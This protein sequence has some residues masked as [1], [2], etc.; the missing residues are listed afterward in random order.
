MSVHFAAARCPARSP[1]ARAFERKPVRQ[2]VNDNGQIAS[3]ID[4]SIRAAL[5]QFAQHG[6]ASVNDA[7]RQAETAHAQGDSAA[8]DHWLNICRSFD[9]R[10]AAQA[11]QRLS[12][13]QQELIG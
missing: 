1:L 4:D 8:V 2:A 5:T 9:P 12:L 10:R 7:I 11:A 6:L 13:A 3:P